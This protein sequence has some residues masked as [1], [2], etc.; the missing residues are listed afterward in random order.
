MSAG[1]DARGDDDWKVVKGGDSKPSTPRGGLAQR[2]VYVGGLA[3][4]TENDVLKGVLENSFGKVSS[5][6]VVTDRETGKSK[7]YGFVT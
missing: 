2:V 3:Q 4:A 6:R 1:D 5:C 7:G